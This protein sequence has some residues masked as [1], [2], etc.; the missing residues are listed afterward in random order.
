MG[1]LHP[2]KTSPFCYPGATPTHCSLNFQLFPA[3]RLLSLLLSSPSTAFYQVLHPIGS[4]TSPW[5]TSHPTSLP[6]LPVAL[7]GQ[8]QTA[9][10]CPGVS[11]IT[12]HAR[13]MGG[14]RRNGCTA[15]SHGLCSR[16]CRDQVCSVLCAWLY[17]SPSFNAGPSLPGSTTFYIKNTKDT[18]SCPK[19]PETVVGSFYPREDVGRSQ[20]QTPLPCACGHLC[21]LEEP[22]GWHESHLRAAWPGAS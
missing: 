14:Q 4:L 15:W 11:P 9:S 6:C 17:V 22:P 21:P 18:L 12:L 7:Q 3:P 8:N 10:S 13:C 19:C 16:P 2:S 1:P 20:A 5:K